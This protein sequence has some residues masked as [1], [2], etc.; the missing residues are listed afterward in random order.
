VTA[1]VI[2]AAV[3]AVAATTVITWDEAENHVGEEVVVKGRVLGVHCSPTACLLAF[4]PGFNRFTAVVQARSFDVLPPERLDDMFSGKKVQVHGTIVLNDRKPEIVIDNPADL[5][6]AIS[7]RAKEERQAETDHAEAQADVVA[8]LGTVLDQIVALT[9]RMA[10]TQER[11]DTLLAQIEQRNAILA[12][13]QQQQAAAAST[14][15]QNWGEPAPRPAYEA[16]RTIKRG[17]TPDQV[18]R[19]IGQPNYTEYGSG[20]WTT[21][22][23]AFGRSVSFDT[24][25]RVQS[26]SGFPNP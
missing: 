11:M 5:K 13:Q 16:L 12:A 19:L 26:F 3:P 7:E 18:V 15:V 22:Y 14:P 6:V 4:E 1:A 20:G 25:G 10:A 2:L 21:W 23:Y 8:R 9:E 17:M 24:R